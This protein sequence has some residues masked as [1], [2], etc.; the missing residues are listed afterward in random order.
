MTVTIEERDKLRNALRLKRDKW[1]I[2]IP[3]KDGY[4]IGMDGF[5]YAIINNTVESV[6][7]SNFTYKNKKVIIKNG[8]FSKR[9][10]SIKDVYYTRHNAENEL[11]KRLNKKWAWGLISYA[12]YGTSISVVGY[13]GEKSTRGESKDAFT[14]EMKPNDA[15]TLLNK[16]HPHSQYIGASYQAIMI[17]RE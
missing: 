8:W 6:L 9:E 3:T 13:L 4:P 16:Y 11:A 15:S 17:D 14:F 7:L 2:G 5:Y 10:F 12:R 1:R